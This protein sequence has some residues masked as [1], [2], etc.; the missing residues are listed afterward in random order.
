MSTHEPVYTLRIMV[1]HPTGELLFPQPDRQLL[2]RVCAITHNG[3]EYV[4]RDYTAEPVSECRTTES[5]VVATFVRFRLRFHALSLEETVHLHVESL[6][7]F[8]KA[9]SLAYSPC[10][11]EAIEPYLQQALLLLRLQ[12]GTA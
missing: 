12:P 11:P 4:I 1:P 5:E 9:P 3:T 8:E 10:N 7:E 2:K 6:A